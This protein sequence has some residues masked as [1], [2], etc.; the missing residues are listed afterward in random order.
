MPFTRSFFR[1]SPA[2][3]R[4]CHSLR[5]L[6]REID[7]R[8]P[9]RSTTADGWIGDS[10]HQSRES[11]HNP[12]GRGVVHALDVTARGIDA[13]HLVARAVAHPA[14]HYVIYDHTMWSRKDGFKPHRYDGPDP[15]E[16]HVHISAG[17]T[18]EQERTS[19][20]WGLS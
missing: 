17:R 8:W 3:P 19:R 20:A 16:T 4:L 2:R 10:A 7:D 13:P 12:D 1:G 14:T 9:G 11:D 5:V 18:H 6:A 15:H